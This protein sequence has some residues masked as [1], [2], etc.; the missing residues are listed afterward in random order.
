M[1]TVIFARGYNIQGQIEYCKAYADKMGYKVDFIVVGQGKDLPA[2]IQGLG[3]KVE[4]VIVRDKTRIC[5]N[6]LDYYTIEADLEIECG[7]VI[8]IA[9]ETPRDHAAENLM[10]NIIMAVR[11]NDARER[12]NEIRKR[13]ILRGML[14]E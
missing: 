8:E 14:E 12:E 4:R 3:V 2:V 7:A 10:R 9:A 11:E 13:L 6:A 1:S 5:R